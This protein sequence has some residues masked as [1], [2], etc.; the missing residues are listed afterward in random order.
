[1]IIAFSYVFTVTSKLH[2]ERLKTGR[3]TEV[4]KHVVE[5]GNYSLTISSPTVV[6]D[7]AL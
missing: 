5:E 3:E 2:R 6:I 4:V 1:M 7:T